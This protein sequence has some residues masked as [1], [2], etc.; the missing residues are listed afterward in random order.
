MLTKVNAGMLS[1]LLLLKSRPLREFKLVKAS[2]VK[3]CIA[4]DERF[5]NC[6]LVRQLKILLLSEVVIRFEERSKISR[7]ADSAQILFGNCAMYEEE[8]VILRVFA[9]IGTWLGVGKVKIMFCSLEEHWMLI[10]CE[11]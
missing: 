1:I 10:I 8:A 7:V 4:F 3:V 2:D 5:R 11:M 6:K 9:R